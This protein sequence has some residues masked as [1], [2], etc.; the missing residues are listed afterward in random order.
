[1]ATAAIARNL[2]DPNRIAIGGYDSGTGIGWL[3]ACSTYMQ[4]K[5]PFKAV[6]VVLGNSGAGDLGEVSGVHPGTDPPFL[7]SSLLLLIPDGF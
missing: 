3:K 6:A 4:G 1:M 7:F 2:A 5:G